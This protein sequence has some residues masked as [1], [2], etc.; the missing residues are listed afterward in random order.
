MCLL[1]RQSR[2]RGNRV[3]CI[4]TIHEL[5]FCTKVQ[6][7][8]LYNIPELLNY[9]LGL[10]CIHLHLIMFRFVVDLEFIPGIVSMRWGKHPG[11]GVSSSHG[12]TH[13][14]SHSDLCL[15]AIQSS[16]STYMG[17]KRKP[18][19][20]EKAHTDTWRTWRTHRQ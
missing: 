10:Y 18:E 9:L 8:L 16:Q 15:Q 3:Q 19:N 13:T 20:S 4:F 1:Q 11:Q 17:G 2:Y 12:N 6:S 7:F 14:H 5:N